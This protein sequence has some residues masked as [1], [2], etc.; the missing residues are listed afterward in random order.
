MNTLTMVAFSLSHSHASRYHAVTYNAVT[1]SRVTPKKCILFLIAT[2]KKRTY[3]VF[4]QKKFE[5]V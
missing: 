2:Q 3:S 4:F 1:L 5:G